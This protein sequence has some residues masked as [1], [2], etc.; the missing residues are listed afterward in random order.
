[1]QSLV[2]T[3]TVCVNDRRSQTRFPVSASLR[4]VAGRSRTGD[5]E[6]TRIDGK[7]INVSVSAILIALDE[8]IEFDR[9]WIRVAEGR[10]GLS[11]CIVVRHEAQ[12][13]QSH[14]YAVK[15]TC[16]WS[17]AVISKLLASLQ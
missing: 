7:V 15:F 4:I 17:A 10:Q 16:D 6:V 8:P 11:E 9:I 14:R 12:D 2:E 3:G 5:I 1:M 13:D